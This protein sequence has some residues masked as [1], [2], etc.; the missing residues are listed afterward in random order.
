LADLKRRWKSSNYSSTSKKMSKLNEHVTRLSS[1][2]RLADLTEMDLALD[3]HNSN[4]QE[5]AFCGNADL[6]DGQ[7]PMKYFYYQ[8]A[9]CDMA[10]QRT[11]NQ[12]VVAVADVK[13]TTVKQHR[14]KEVLL[15]MNIPSAFGPYSCFALPHHVTTPVPNEDATSPPEDH[16]PT[17]DL[18][19]LVAHSHR[20]TDWPVTPL[21][22]STTT[23]F[24][25]IHPSQSLEKS[26]F[27]EAESVDDPISDSNVYLSEQR[28]FL[29]QQQQSSIVAQHIPATT[30]LCES[31]SSTSNSLP[32]SYTRSASP[33][34]MVQ[35]P[36]IPE[37]HNTH[38]CSCAA[39]E[40]MNTSVVVSP[41]SNSASPPVIRHNNTNNNITSPVSV[42]CMWE[43]GSHR[44]SGSSTKVTSP[45]NLLLSRANLAKFSM[46]ATCISP[47]AAAGRGSTHL[48]HPQ[49]VLKDNRATTTAA[50]PS[51]MFSL[52]PRFNT[53]E[54]EMNIIVP[55]NTLMSSPFS[56]PSPTP[57]E[58][59][60]PEADDEF[61]RTLDAPPTSKEANSPISLL[62]VAIQNRQ[63]TETLLL[64]F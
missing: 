5:A 64:Y 43:H 63:Q 24:P 60:S 20:Q 35:C 59:C 44:G 56:S 2:E 11:R 7:C 14:D 45:H 38:S 19:P 29:R 28:Q 39:M 34:T 1:S 61:L 42:V 58:E 41:V 37:S 40:I 10:R 23:P 4:L 47:A 51:L 46:Y 25:I 9:V 12:P 27:Q 3:P 33:T 54:H 53:T 31:V 62:T 57:S 16:H 13:S 30:C 26:F 22:P 32:I 55:P 15:N 52:S 36:S 49:M 18:S 21:V 48:G 50:T 17:P 8:L 6:S